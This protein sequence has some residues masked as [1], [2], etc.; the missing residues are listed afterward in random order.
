[1]RSADVIGTRVLA[2]SLHDVVDELERRI[3]EV[4]RGYVCFANAH[5]T[6]TARG[7][8]ETARA[9]GEAGMVL[10]DGAPVAWALRFLTGE[11]TERIAGSDVFAELC[12]RSQRRGYRHFFLGSTEETL[13]RVRRNAA[14]R[15]PDLQVCGSLSPPFGAALFDQ[16]PLITA[17]INEAQ[18]DV[19]WVG[20]GAP[21][22]EQWMRAA[23]PLIEAPLL[24]GVGAVFDFVAGNKRRAPSWMQRA[25]LEWAHRLAHEPRRL[26]RRYVVTNTAFSLALVRQLMGG[27][28]GR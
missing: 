3:L 5:L 2:G 15:Y 1:M 4:E 16:L 6:S 9:L 10:A 7:D 27:T 24:L 18:P 26:A 11:A 14:E 22:Q 13:A 8:R 23:R 12:D 17:Q 28:G 25:G 20:L 21:R 19:V